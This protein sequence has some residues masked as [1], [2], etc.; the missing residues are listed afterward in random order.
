MYGDSCKGIHI[1]TGDLVN[2]NTKEIVDHFYY[3]YCQ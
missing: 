2:I 1:Y 3:N